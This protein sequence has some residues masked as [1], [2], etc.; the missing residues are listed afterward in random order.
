M[1]IVGLNLTGITANA[2]TKDV[3]ETINVNS[4]PTIERIDKKDIDMPGVKDVLAI[5]FRFRTQY[6]PNVGDIAVDGEILYH[7][8][9]NR[10]ILAKW[11]KERRVEDDVAAELLNAIFRKCLTEAIHVAQELRL[12]PPIQFP[13]VVPKDQKK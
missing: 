3:K 6:E 1:P 11:K 7:S 9:K 12:P 8:D 10:D 2:D 5:G 4:T 13:V